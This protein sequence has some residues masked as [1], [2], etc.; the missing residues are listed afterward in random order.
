MNLFYR[1]TKIISKN[2]RERR[3]KNQPNVEIGPT[4]SLKVVAVGGSMKKK[5]QKFFEAQQIQVQND[6]EPRPLP[7][8]KIYE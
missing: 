8:S 6:R 3:A 2:H 4:I 5:I 1:L 7:P